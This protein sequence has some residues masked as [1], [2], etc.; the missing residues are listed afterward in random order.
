MSIDDVGLAFNP[1]IPMRNKGE[2]R[3]SVVWCA[4]C[5][6]KVVLLLWM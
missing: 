1:K 2:R 5:Q 3:S 6:W 4:D